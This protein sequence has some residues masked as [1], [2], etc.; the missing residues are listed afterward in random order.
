MKKIYIILIGLLGGQLNAQN[1]PEYLPELIEKAIKKDYRVLEKETDVELDVIDKKSIQQM[2]IPRVSATGAFVHTQQKITADI[3]TVHIP[4]ISPLLPASIFNGNTEINAKANI[5]GAGATAKMLLFSGMQIPMA[6]KAYT[7]KIEA[8]KALTEAQKVI[9]IADVLKVHDQIALIYEANKVLLE[10]KKRLN[11]EEKRINRA[12][13]LGLATPFDRQKIQSASLTLQSKEVEIE[14]KKELLF[15][16]LSLLTNTDVQQLKE[17]SYELNLW[18]F[19]SQNTEEIDRPEIDAINQGIIALSYKEKVKKYRYL[20][21][22]AA[23]ANVAYSN[24]WNGELNT[25]TINPITQKPVEL[26]LNKLEFKPAFFAG[27]GIKWEIFD[28]LHGK[29]EVEKIKVQRHLMEEKKKYA[30]EQFS[31]L[32]KK[33]QTDLRIIKKQLILKEKNQA[34]A[35][36]TLKIAQH[37]YEQGFKAHGATVFI[38]HYYWQV[39]NFTFFV[40]KS[41]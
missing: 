35:K 36:S 12:I 31:L 3:P 13:E 27:V 37:S 11:F 33:T 25:S 34:L 23:F 6:A 32:T 39:G 41:H 2:Y 21:K 19:D 14:G 30:E 28:G 1:I 18:F 5:I 40:Y 22:V 20:P 29:H 17:Y 10:S 9:V 16:K 26:K 15:E 38:Y 7:H 8:K 24:V 4:P